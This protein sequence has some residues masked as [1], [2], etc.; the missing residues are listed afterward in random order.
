MRGKE[1]KFIL[2]QKAEE[3]GTVAVFEVLYGNRWDLL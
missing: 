1:V 2:K 3:F